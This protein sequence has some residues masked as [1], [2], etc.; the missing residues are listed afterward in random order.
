MRYITNSLIILDLVH[1]LQSSHIAHGKWLLASTEQYGLTPGPDCCVSTKHLL[2]C[3]Y[4]NL[5]GMRYC[6]NRGLRFDCTL[7]FLALYRVV[8]HFGE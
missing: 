3:R 1:D 5:P 8:H 6:A 4:L 7:F 2:N